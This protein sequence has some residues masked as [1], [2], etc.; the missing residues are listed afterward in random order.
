MPDKPTA[1]PSSSP[2]ASLG[3]DKALLRATQRTAPPPELATETEET[4]EAPPALA[5]STPPRPAKAKK[6]ASNLASTQAS[7]LASVSPDAAQVIEAI[8]RIV[9]VPGKEVSFVRLTQNEKGQLT[10]IVYTYKRRGHRTTENEIN[11]IAVNF[12]LE[13]YHA[14]GEASVLARVLEA[15]QA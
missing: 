12:I 4:E 13:D 10:D 7:T 14:H 2:F 1:P 3:T 9:K 15:L 11:R 8:R 6:P 5:A